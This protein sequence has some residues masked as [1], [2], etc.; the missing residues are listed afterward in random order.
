MQCSFYLQLTNQSNQSQIKSRS[1]QPQA[2]KYRYKYTLIQRPRNRVGPLK[3]RN[4]RQVAMQPKICSRPINQPKSNTSTNAKYKYKYKYKYIY[5]DSRASCQHGICCRLQC[6]PELQLTNQSNPT[7]KILI[8][9]Y[10]LTN[11]KN[12]SKAQQKNNLHKN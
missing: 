6:N 1:A 8:Q 3:A 4:F 10:K 11:D 5:I 7:Q 2:Q 12:T 9:K